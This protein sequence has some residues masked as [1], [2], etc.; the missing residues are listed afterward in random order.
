LLFTHR[1]PYSIHDSNP[2]IRERLGCPDLLDDIV[3]C[4]RPRI[5]LFGHMYSCHG[6]SLYKNEDNRILEDDNVKVSSNDILLI[7]LAIHQGRTFDQATARD[8]FY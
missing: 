8:Y 4:I 3:T 1:P 2:S 6:A 7:N 5:R